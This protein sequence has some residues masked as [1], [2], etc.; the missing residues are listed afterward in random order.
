MHKNPDVE[1]WT[2]HQT[3]NVHFFSMGH[4]RQDAIYQEVSRILPRGRILEIGF[5]DGYLLNKLSDRYD[6]FASDISPENVSQ[7]GRKYP[8]IEFKAIE[9]DGRLPYPD[10]FFDLFI[11]SEVL[12]HMTDEE[13][14]T[15]IPEIRRV[16]KNSGHAIITFPARE[17]LA[18]NACFCPNCGYNFHRWGHKQSWDAA[19]IKQVFRDFT[20]VSLKER[21][22]LP[23]GLNMAGKLSAYLKI[24]LSR[25]RSMSEMT[26]LVKLRK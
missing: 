7:M 13:L 12:E 16:L 6:C 26:Y 8:Q 4:P 14:V 22:F 24:M 10:N 20:I 15:A 5:G 11:A 18:D 21:Y 19:R 2:L 9:P 25:V 23:P 1:M 3:D 17:N